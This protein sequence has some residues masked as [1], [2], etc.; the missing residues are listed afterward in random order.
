M[1]CSWNIS[2]LALTHVKETGTLSA[3]LAA[4]FGEMALSIHDGPTPDPAGVSA[5]MKLPEGISREK[6]VRR[7]AFFAARMKEALDHR[8][9]H[10]TAL[11]ALADVFPEQ[12]AEAPRSSKSRFADELRR[13]STGPAV[14]STFG[15]VSKN[16]RS[17]G[18]APS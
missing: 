13:G 16:P 14:A 6:A 12:L 8:D 17:Y 9:D 18:D 11:A 2:A 7:L 15:A 1:L 3:S 4:F 10:A 5:P